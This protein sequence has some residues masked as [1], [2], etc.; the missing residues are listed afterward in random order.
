MLVVFL[1][2]ME[3]IVTDFFWITQNSVFHV[4]QSLLRSRD[5]IR[6]SFSVPRGIDDF[7]WKRIF[8]IDQ[9]FHAEH[10]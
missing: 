3:Q 2:H 1:F 9:V 4:E 7:L 10:K 6:E 5:L 8:I